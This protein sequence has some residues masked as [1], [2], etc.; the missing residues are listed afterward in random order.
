MHYIS[1]ESKEVMINNSFGGL[2]FFFNCDMEGR[3]LYKQLCWIM[4]KFRIL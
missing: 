1:N 3:R 4:R 2:I